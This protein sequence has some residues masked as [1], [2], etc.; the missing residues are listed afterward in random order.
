M[1]GLRIDERRKL[2]FVDGVA[3]HVS[4]KEFALLR[5]LASDSGR[6]YSCGE[7]LEAVWNGRRRASRSDVRQVI[8]QLRRRIEIDP[9]SPR[10]V[11]T[12]SGFGY[13]ISD[14][15][16]DGEEVPGD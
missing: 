11:R 12:A 15:T 14:Y 5:L 16:N 9:A 3:V 4:G 7:I 10:W 8:Y 2:V 1:Q 13:F 6:V